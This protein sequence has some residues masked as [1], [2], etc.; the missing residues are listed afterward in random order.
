MNRLGTKVFSS[1][2]AMS[3]AASLAACGGGARSALPKPPTSTAPD[4]TGPLAD[5]TFHISIPG[6]TK[7]SARARRPSYVSS[8]TASLKFVINSSTTV[9]GT[10]STGTLGS[11]NA[12]AWH[13]F[14]TGTMPSTACPVDGGHAGNF[15]CTVVIKIPPG[16]DNIT[17]SA[18][19]GTN[20]TGNLLSQQIQT[21]TVTAGGSASGA[22]NF[23][24]VLDANANTMSLS[25]T[26]PCT[27]GSIQGQFGSS[28][29]TSAVTI[30]VN[31]TD[32]AGK[33]IVAPGEPVIAIQDADTTF[34]TTSGVIHGTGGDAN[35]SINQ[36][37]QS[38]T[39]TP[40]A[41]PLSNVPVVVH[42]TPANTN[43]TSDGLG[44]TQSHS[45][46]FSAGSAPPTS[47]FLAIIE[48]NT[49]GSSGQINFFTTSLGGSGG[50]DSLTAWTTPT[51]ADTLSISSPQDN[52][53]DNPEDL[54]WDTGGNL[55]I[56]NGGQGGSNNGSPPHAD[57]GNF[58]CVP[59]GAIST[60]ANLST[61]IQTNI[62][63]P[64]AIAYETRNGTVAIA[65]NPG[66]A[67][68]NVQS[69]T[70]STN[71][72]AGSSFANPGS[73]GVP[74]G[75]P[76]VNL[77]TLTAG[78]FAFGIFDGT[79]SQVVILGPTGTA[80][81]VTNSGDATLYDPFA[82]AWDAKNTQL[83]VGT[84]KA[85]D[86]YLQQ[87]TVSNPPTA[88]VKVNS[89]RLQPDPDPADDCPGNPPSCS[90]L[91]A[92]KIAVAPT[93]GYVAVAGVNTYNSTYGGEEIQLYD[94]T[95]SHNP[96]ANGVI[97]YDAANTGALACA[98][99]GGNN[100]TTDY[101][102]GESG[103]AIKDL[104][105]LSSTKLLVLLSQPN[106]TSVQGIYIYDVSATAAQTGFWGPF[107]GGS[108]V[109]TAVPNG[110]KNTYFQN[111]T[112]LAPFAAAFK[113]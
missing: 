2:L 9:S 6:P 77:P 99:P 13:L 54:A 12:L 65:N 45:F 35:F 24:T 53:V 104:K 80:A 39:L 47:N 56:A 68:K 43:T 50:P 29:G 49:S 61:T 44:F 36:S 20:G 96:L 18:Y 83:I 101:V 84:N 113:P 38:F 30:N 10:A 28:Q 22:N 33:T 4:Y 72:V 16:S 95:T 110:P 89:F 100:P 86:S 90:G 98:A 85:H 26:Q 71:Y 91:Q 79:N 94:G 87:Y 8:A 102:F 64:D 81:S 41:V 112:T 27:A 37:T 82:M 46:T 40:T 76:L 32:L 31:F 34:H 21:F 11:Y 111:L 97:A 70:L 48:Q 23:S 75:R 67:T 15:L 62:K 42:A 55:L 60:G 74:L 73:Y 59:A 14:N 103:I 66:S 69:F 3:F 52:D 17:I 58:A 105:W 88:P 25:G 63:V 7:T 93:T 57:F 106:K 108:C 19:D 107:S 109:Q 92:Q 1:V 5:A 51:L 78:T